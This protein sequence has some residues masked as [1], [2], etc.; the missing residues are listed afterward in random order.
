MDG[1]YKVHCAHV[2][3]T[4]DTIVYCIAQVKSAGLVHENSPMSMKKCDP[5]FQWREEL[6]GGLA[7]NKRLDYSK[8]YFPIWKLF[9]KGFKE[10]NNINNNNNKRHKSR[11][12]K[13]IG[14]NI[15]DVITEKP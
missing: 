7:Q 9:H 12:Y 14:E 11:E 2:E 3:K 15:R 4:T 1:T 5:H 6:M 8:F 13:Y 10:Q